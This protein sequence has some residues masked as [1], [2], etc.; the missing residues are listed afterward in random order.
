M[1]LVTVRELVQGL[2]TRT[3][4]SAVLAF[5]TGWGHSASLEASMCVVVVVRW[6]VC[7]SPCVCLCQTVG[8][9]VYRAVP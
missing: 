5:E 4:C 6:C 1:Y 2:A 3:E 9:V 8:E 7:G